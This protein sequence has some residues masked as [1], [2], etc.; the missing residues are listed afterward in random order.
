MTATMTMTTSSNTAPRWLLGPVHGSRLHIAPVCAA[1]PKAGSWVRLAVQ[2]RVAFEATR[3]WLL[4]VVPRRHRRWRIGPEGFG[5]YWLS[6]R[7]A[8]LL[9]AA[10][11]AEQA[12]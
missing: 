12:S 8:A 7:G 4:H 11:E 1:W 6:R 9:L 10:V 5:C 2:D 3:D